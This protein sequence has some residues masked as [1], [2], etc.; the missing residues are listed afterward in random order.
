LRHVFVSDTTVES[1]AANLEENRKGILLFRDELTAWVRGLDQYKGRGTDRQF[2]LSSWSGEMVKV[3]R[4]Y[5][6][7]KP[8]IIPHPFIGVLGGIQP[9]L[10][11][12]LEAEG[13]KED[14]FI[15][16]ILFSYPVE[17]Q[18]QEWTDEEVS[19]EDEQDWQLVLA[20][21]LNLQ[22]IKPEGSSERPKRLQFSPEGKAAFVA[23]YDKLVAEMKAV[24]FQSELFG[25]WSKL[26]A[27]CAR[28]ALIIH[29]LRVAC[30]EAG[31][32]QDE[33]Q[34]DV[35]DV[36]RAEKLCDYFKAHFKVVYG[37]LQQSKEDQRVD[38]L[39]AWMQKKQLR[40][41]TPRD[42]CRSNVCGIKR[43]SEAERLL[44]AASDRGLG[45]TELN[46]HS[47]RHGPEVHAFMLPDNP[48]K[49]G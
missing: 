46:G 24:E 34:V 29:M 38:S 6:Q 16:R 10:L 42:I 9:D 36:A 40:R 26:K 15:H 2:F 4:K 32:G 8:T 37:R 12:E 48:T 14:G 21:L 20:W 19:E 23:W 22:P 28:F 41:V 11:T 27:H 43:T 30:D 5:Q 25:P 44:R 17:G 31:N 3:D 7:G 1:L 13:G 18:V 33:G 39:L 47:R 45:N 35:E 49:S